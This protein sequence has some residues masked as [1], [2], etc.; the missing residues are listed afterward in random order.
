MPTRH[1]AAAATA[2]RVMA[3]I[4]S[5]MLPP[6]VSHSTID[7]SARPR[8][9]PGPSASAYAE[10]ALPAVEEV[11]GVVDHLAAGRAPDEPT[12]VADHRQVL[13]ERDAQ[14]LA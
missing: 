9:R 4:S 12:A 7:P 3:A 6:L 1:G 13:V 11:L 14:D 5:G 10:F 8:R 2:C